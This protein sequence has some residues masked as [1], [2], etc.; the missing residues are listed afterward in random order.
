VQF[1]Y[2]KYKSH[3]VYIALSAYR[4]A[5]LPLY[6]IWVFQIMLKFCGI[7]KITNP[8]GKVYVGQS[9]D[10]LLRFRQYKKMACRDQR[11]L[12]F[13][14]QKYGVKNHVFEIIQ[15]CDRGEL[16]SLECYYINLFQSFNTINGLNLQSGGGI[17]KASEETKQRMSLS[18]KGKKFSSEHRKNISI[19]MEGAIPWNKGKKMT[20]EQCIKISESKMGDNNPAKNYDVRKKISDKAK[21]RIMTEETKNKISNKSK[22]RIFTAEHKKNLRLAWIKRKAK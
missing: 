22:G 12:Y 5:G 17:T 11:K 4:R 8:K 3:I 20:Y 19:S 21:L 10:I 14:F 2:E 15:T 18:R 1:S 9:I 16:N 7:Y 6:S 13:S